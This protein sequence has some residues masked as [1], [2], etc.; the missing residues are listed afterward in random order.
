LAQTF[1]EKPKPDYFFP[2]FSQYATKEELVMLIK[3]GHEKN[4]QMKKGKED[5]AKKRSLKKIGQ[6]EKV[7]MGNVKSATLRHLLGDELIGQL[8][9]FIDTMA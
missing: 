1:A 7:A 5:G 2:L 8:G 6:L 3:R 4:E 9:D